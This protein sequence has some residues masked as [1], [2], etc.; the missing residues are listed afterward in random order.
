MTAID[1]L[2]LDFEL[3][4]QLQT[5]AHRYANGECVAKPDSTINRI[6]NFPALGATVLTVCAVGEPDCCDTYSFTT[7]DC[8]LFGQCQI[9]ELVAEAGECNSDSTYGLVLEFNSLNLDIDSVIIT[10]NGNFIGQYEVTNQNISIAQFPVFDTP[11]TT[12]SVCA[13]GEPDCC[14]SFE[15]ETPMFHSSACVIFGIW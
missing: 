1:S 6:E 8:S 7:P 15:F 13:V 9:N 2:G 4:M 5:I 12:L 11:V 10:G 3:T 14:D